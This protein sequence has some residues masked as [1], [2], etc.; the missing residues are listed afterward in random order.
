MADCARSCA[1]SASADGI[2]SASGVITR[3]VMSSAAIKRQKEGHA[4]GSRHGPPLL[5]ICNV[6]DH[7]SDVVDDLSRGNV[8]GGVD[9]REAGLHGGAEC[10]A[11]SCGHAHQLRHCVKALALA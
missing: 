8:P 3:T 10:R 7:R 11:L 1:G 9:L 5:L 4:F 6:L 2:T